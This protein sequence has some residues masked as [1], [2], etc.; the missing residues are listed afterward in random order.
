MHARHLKLV[1]EYDGGDFAGW[2]VQPGQR[3]VQG[4]L[5]DALADLI[6]EESRLVGAGRTDAGVHALAMPAHVDVASELPADTIRDALNA[7]LPDDVFLHEVADAPSSFHARHSATARSYVYLIGLSESPVWRR[8]RW[9][10]RG[11]LD[12]EA[13]DAALEP[14]RGELDFSS[15]CLTGSEPEHHRCRV[16]AISIECERRYGGMIVFQIR[17]NRFLRGMVRSIVGTL[18]EVGRGRFEPAAMKQVVDAMDRSA[19]GP[20]APAHGLYLTRVEY[21]RGGMR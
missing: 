1:V 2:Q 14:L 20:T 4:T 9:F 12:L 16:D 17:A 10:A 11:G 18:V 7:R 8:H 5:E 19:A 13:M 21:E 15:F 6:G 3:T